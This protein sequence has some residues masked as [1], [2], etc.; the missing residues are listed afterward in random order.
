MFPPALRSIFL[1]CHP[2]PVEGQNKKDAAPIL[3]ANPAN[4]KAFIL[5]REILFVGI[6]YIFENNKTIR[7]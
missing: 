6:F 7:R 1:F 4:K 3:N 5:Q 2:E